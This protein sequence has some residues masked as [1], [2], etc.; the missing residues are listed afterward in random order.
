MCILKMKTTDAALLGHVSGEALS[1]SALS[2]LWTMCTSVFIQGGVLGIL[3]SSAVGS[4]NPKLA[5]IYLQVSY[6]VLS[7]IA[8]FVFIAWNVTEQ[9]WVVF[10]SNPVTSHDAGYYARVLSFG[11]PG[12][13][14]YSQLRQFFSAQR[15]MR[16]EVNAATIALV[17]NLAFGLAFVLGIPFRNF[18][19]F[20]FMACPIVTT[21][22]VYIQIAFVY[23]VYVKGQ[24]LHEEC[25][26]GW[27][28]K[29]MTRDRIKIFCDLYF[30][31]AFGSAS[32]FWRVAAIGAVAA[33]M[34]EKEVAVFNTS[35]RVMWI[36][37]III[38]AL[39]Q[40]SGVKI[41]MR[42]G[43]L[44]PV[45]AKQAG[46]VGL[47]LC[48]VTLCFVS[49]LVLWKVRFLGTIFTND[50]DFL[51][52]FEECSVP[53]TATLFLMNFSIAIEKIPY[54][55]GRTSEVFW[56]GLIASWGFQVPGVLVCTTYWRKD[57]VGLYTGMSIGYLALCILYGN[58]AFRSDWEKYAIL[59]RSR[60]EARD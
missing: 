11:I 49:L 6:L 26:G 9:V 34:G 47:V 39:S 53:F 57:L 13:I 24:R 38:S 35:Y 44:N 15:I 18:E 41:S 31:D 3:V 7:V 22:C 51:L 14:A 40:A 54:S 23:F 48:F 12:L 33:K 36:T 21:F 16:P 5:G 55:M 37:L 25:W 59:S 56:M 45:G 43:K 2:D 50:E 20:G 60:S 28:W 27:S 29:E 30:P 52:M 32:D 10:G 46:E 1:A 19:G 17:L 4:D 8:I 42:L 58:I